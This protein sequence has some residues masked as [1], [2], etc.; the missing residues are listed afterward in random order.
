MCGCRNSPFDFPVRARVGQPRAHPA[1]RLSSSSATCAARLPSGREPHPRSEEPIE[2]ERSRPDRGEQ[3]R[4]EAEGT[5]EF[6]PAVAD[7][8]AVPHVDEQ[9]RTEH[10]QEQQHPPEHGDEQTQD[11]RDPPPRISA[12]V[13]MN[14]VTAGTGTSMPSNPALVPA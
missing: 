10:V 5:D 12:Q 6:P 8:D 11:Q 7:V 2:S 14:A 3:Q 4:T 1:A 13:A 9:V